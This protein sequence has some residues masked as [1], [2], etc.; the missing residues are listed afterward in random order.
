MDAL[1][2]VA[3]HVDAVGEALQAYAAELSELQGR[4]RAV[5]ESAAASGLALTEGRVHERW[6]VSGEADQRTVSDRD[7]QARTLQ[8][9]LDGVAVQHR[10]RRDRLLTRV[11]G[12]RQELA[13]LARRCGSAE[14]AR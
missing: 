8:A 10:R 7:A 13:D 9:E 5:A 6:G 12:S 4:E 1:A 3:G 11:A 14:L 2:H